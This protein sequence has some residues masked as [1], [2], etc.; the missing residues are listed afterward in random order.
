MYMYSIIYLVL[1]QSIILVF[2]FQ[3]KVLFP[4]KDT[5][6]KKFKFWSSFIK[7]LYKNVENEEALV[8]YGK[9]QWLWHYYCY[10]YYYCV[11]WYALGW[12]V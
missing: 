9:G 8:L 4:S 1:Y 5:W 11:V 10:Y 2:I 3:I 12:A 6:D 7:Y